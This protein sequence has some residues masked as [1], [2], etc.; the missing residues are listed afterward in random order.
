MK[1]SIKA[2]KLSIEKT[3]LEERKKRESVK[4]DIN[5]LLF[6]IQYVKVKTELINKR[7]TLGES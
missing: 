6:N 2:Q 7:K 4:M 1:K 5:G 3:Q